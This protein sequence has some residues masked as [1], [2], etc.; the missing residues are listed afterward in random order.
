MAVINWAVA[1]V[2][3]ATPSTLG[4]A[5]RGIVAWRHGVDKQ[6]IAGRRRHRLSGDDRD[7]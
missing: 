4:I 6:Q 2:D 3:R 1:G 7:A 5:P